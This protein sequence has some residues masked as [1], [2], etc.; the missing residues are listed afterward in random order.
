MEN[1]LLDLNV[2]N[3]VIKKKVPVFGTTIEVPLEQ[4]ILT[5]VPDG[6]VNVGNLMTVINKL[7]DLGDNAGIISAVQKVVDQIL[8]IYPAAADWSISFKRPTESGVIP[9]SRSIYKPELQHSSRC[10]IPDN[11]TSVKRC[12]TGVQ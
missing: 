1:H 2:S 5:L 3:I 8:K 4:A 11:C 9:C 12:K 7:P 6:K 10:W